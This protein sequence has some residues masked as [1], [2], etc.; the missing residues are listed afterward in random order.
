MQEPSGIEQST[1]DGGKSL[2]WRLRRSFLTMI[3][4]IEVGQTTT[5]GQDQNQSS[6]SS[7]ALYSELSLR[8]ALSPLGV[9]EDTIGLLNRGMGPPWPALIL[10]DAGLR[11][12]Q[13]QSILERNA[14]II[15]TG[16]R[17]GTRAPLGLSRI[18]W[19]S[20]LLR[21]GMEL[22]FTISD[23][24]KLRN[25]CCVYSRE[26]NPGAEFTEHR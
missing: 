20:V 17:Y 5:T 4:I 10:V 14:G 2:V 18:W 21:G 13:T 7:A 9:A 12:S 19:P 22:R 24:P 25:Q 23:R 16:H 3:C 15:R 26:W 6:S 1:L 11:C 8:E